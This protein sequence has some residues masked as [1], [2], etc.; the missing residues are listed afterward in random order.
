MLKSG[1][2]ERKEVRVR[3][4]AGEGCRR[5]E[6]SEGRGRCRACRAL[7]QGDGADLVGVV[8]LLGSVGVV[9]VV[10]GGESS[11]AGMSEAG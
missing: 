6:R 10:G 5:R 3:G 11:S 7:R 1:S 2:E 9:G 8:V 4:S